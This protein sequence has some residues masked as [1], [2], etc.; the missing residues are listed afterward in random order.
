MQNSLTEIVSNHINIIP[1]IVS[2]ITDILFL[3]E[4]NKY[5]INYKGLWNAKNNIPIITSSK[6]EL[7]DVYKVFVEGFQKID[8][9]E[10]WIED[11]YLIFIGV[12]IKI[13]NINLKFNN[14]NTLLLS[15]KKD[16]I[17]DSGLSVT[18]D[19]NQS[20]NNTIFTSFATK[21]IIRNLITPSGLWNA[22][23][24]KPKLA[25]KAGIKGISY[26]VSKSGFQSI[27]SGIETYYN[28]GEIIY[29]NNLTK[30]WDKI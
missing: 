17:I 8:T 25:L 5:T 18:N 24:N 13:P 19:C 26:I 30:V 16:T 27:L 6:G 3:L 28:S 11:D 20:S 2:N 7:Y 9:N 12:W 15:S 1:S 10:I 14:L 21:S 22:K 29:Y 4:T 23:E